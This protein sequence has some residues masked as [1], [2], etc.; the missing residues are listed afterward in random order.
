MTD[1]KVVP[2]PNWTQLT[3][4]QK[5]EWR[6]QNFLNPPSVKFVSQ[7][8]AQNYHERAQ[9]LVKALTLQEPDQIPVSPPIAGL[10]FLLYEVDYY[11]AMYDHKLTSQIFRRFNAEHGE[12]FETLASPVWVLPGK[13][14]DILNYRS[15][16]YPG[17][18]LS[19]TSIGFQF[20]ENEY[21]LADEYDAF[22]RNP[23][24]FFMRTYMPRAY[25]DLQSF[26]FLPNFTTANFPPHMF[27]MPYANPEVQ[28]TQLKLIEV[29]KALAE[30]MQMM[31]EFEGQGPELGFPAP[32]GGT[33]FAPFD[34][35][36]DGLR[37][38]QGIIRDMYR[39]PE[40]LLAALDIVTDLTIN[41][42]LS[43]PNISRG[44]RVWFPLHKGADGWMSRKQ[45]ETFYWS[46]LKRVM[47]AFIK[48]GLQIVLFAEGS[49][50]TRLESVTDFP[51]GSVHWQFDQTDMLKAKKVLGSKFSIEGNVPTSLL[52]TGAPQS[53]KEYC[54]KLFE[55]C[56]P[57]GGFILAAGASANEIKYENALA[58]MQAA[59][60]SGQYH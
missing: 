31:K 10:P 45:F 50:N 22:I 60:E 7:R 58:M 32:T 6:F 47:D 42:V 29:G 39:Q 25:G 12:E 43:S 36:G 55:I 34:T 53:V 18:G 4:E 27:F 51:R 8:A 23:S 59:R 15:Y 1:S 48:E 2:T 40:K 35:I 57:G 54:R 52:V 3:P 19:K 14:Y 17:H 56:A 38:T 21:M 41:T 5:R 30:R 37:G 46:S 9:R 26:S 49:Y 33:A 20:V 13:V 28:E 11:S 44:M 16:A 24:D